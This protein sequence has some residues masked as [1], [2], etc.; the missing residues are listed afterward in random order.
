MPSSDLPEVFAAQLVFWALL[1]FVLFASPRWAVLAWLVM[2]NLDATGPSQAVSVSIGWINVAK[3]IVLP[4]LLWW[5]MR[6]VPGRMSSTLPAKLWV[7]LTIYAAVATL[8]APFP[9]AG[10]KLVGNMI[11]ILLMLIVMEKSARGGF[12]TARTINLL[13]LASLGLGI[14][15]TFYFGGAAY[16]F[17]GPDQP[18]RF[19]SFVAAQQ[20]AAFLVA[21]LAAVL[22]QFESSLRIRLPLCVA[23]CT[24]LLLN[25]SRTWFLGASLVL[26]VYMCLSFRRVFAIS[27][28]IFASAILCVLLALNLSP[29]LQMDLVEDTSSR[30]A[31]T[32]TAL[33]TGEDTSHHVGLA[34]PELQASHLRRRISGSGDQRRSRAFVGA[35]HFERGQCDPASVSCCV[36]ARSGG[37]QPGHSQRVEPRAV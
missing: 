35:R 37:S 3:G 30:I 18:S 1:P 15:Q 23:I 6:R 7:A 14:V 36:Y 34:E 32:L 29:V 20:Y 2:G 10:V 22:W 5:R 21:F 24:A 33:F 9:L 26:A 31:A 16:G 19:S 27:S 17:D 12:L 4:L 13:V 25:G 8:W 11:G 28:L